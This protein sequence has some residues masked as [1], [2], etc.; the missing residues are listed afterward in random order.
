[1]VD[2]SSSLFHRTHDAFSLGTTKKG[3]GP[4]YSSKV[5]L[6][7][8][9]RSTDPYRAL[10]ATRN[11]IRMIDLIGDFSIFTEKFVHS[12]SLLRVLISQFLILRDRLRSLYNYYK[13][14][15]PD[16]DVDIE[17]IIEQFKKLADYFRPMTIDTIAYLNE[18]IIDGSKRILVEGANATMLDI[19]FG[20]IHLNETRHEALRL[21]RHLSVCDLIQLQCRWRMYRS[22][23]CTEVHWRHL[24]CCES[25]HDACRRR[26]L[27]N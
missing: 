4:T 1:M 11:G 21:S 10:Q 19:D 25:V 17:K 3:I 16:L 20:T 7:T 14:T 12:S 2:S 26:C 23:S 15:F 22:G 18:T 9:G 24:W 6:V 27:S 13:L 5:R 8:V